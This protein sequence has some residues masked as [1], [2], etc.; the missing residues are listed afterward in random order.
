MK[1]YTLENGIVINLKYVT[2]VDTI[3]ASTYGTYEYSIAIVGA[4]RPITG[5]FS[6]KETAERSRNKLLA[7]FIV[8]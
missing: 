6:S 8:V 2:Y 7:E 1:Y 5:V 3:K 4:E